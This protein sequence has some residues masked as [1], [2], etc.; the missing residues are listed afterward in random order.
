MQKYL[1][2][3]FNKKKTKIKKQKMKCDKTATIKTCACCTYFLCLGFIID[4]YFIIITYNIQVVYLLFKGFCCQ[5]QLFSRSLLLWPWMAVLYV[6]TKVIF[7]LK[8]HSPRGLILDCIQWKGCPRP[9]QYLKLDNLI[10]VAEQWARVSAKIFSLFLIYSEHFTR[11]RFFF[12]DTEHLSKTNL[13]FPS[14]GATLK[15]W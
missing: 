3:A 12:I 13:I 9:I 6:F 15:K 8:Q 11:T 7:C 5:I 14:F 2:P 1:K 4:I 10:T